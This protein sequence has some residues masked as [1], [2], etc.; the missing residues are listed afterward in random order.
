M[1][2]FNKYLKCGFF[3]VSLIVFASCEPDEQG[4]ED[5][6]DNDG[7]EV[8]LSAER[9]LGHGQYR[10]RAESG[11]TVN[12]ELLVESSEP[13]ST[14]IIT[15]TVN[16][17]IDS[18]FGTSGSKSIDLSGAVFEY[19]FTYTTDTTD[20]DQ[21]VGFT[22]E[23]ANA[24]GE[25]EVSDLNLIVTLSP[26]DNLPRRRW[27]LTSIL[28]VNEGNAE[29]INECE[30][31]NS[32]LLNADSTMV[33]DYGMDTGAGACAFDGFNVYTKWYLSAD[34]STF[35]WEYYG[36]FSPDNTVVESFEV[37]T[38]TT[39]ELGLSLTVDL[40]VFGLGIETFLYIYEATPR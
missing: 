22:F 14:L 2:L 28:H 4:P 33:M 10:A 37:E 11:D 35:T 19:D 23:V 26:R 25:V 36:I 16:L 17:E 29:V 1:K 30:K 38:L 9:T 27:A 13:L 31:D 6:Y 24:V 40:T 15:K 39:E 3:F 8:A 18:T 32:F 12:V 7:F 5:Y 34:E 20:I 21:L